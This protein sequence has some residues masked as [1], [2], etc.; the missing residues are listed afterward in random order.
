VKIV[1]AWAAN[2]GTTPIGRIQIGDTVAKTF[3]ANFDHV[4]LDLV[5]G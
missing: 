3:T 1:N 2:T 5:V 4:V